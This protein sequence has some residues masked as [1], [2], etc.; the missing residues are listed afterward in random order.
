[1]RILYVAMKYDYG[2]LEQGYSFEHYNFYHS[3]LHMGHDIIYFDFMTLMQKYGRKRMNRLLLEAVRAKKPG[4]LF[5]V[6]F[7]NELDQNV[8]R[9][10]SESTDIVTLNWFCDDH[11]RFDSFSRYWAPCFDSVVT[12]AKSALPKYEKLGYRNVIKSQWACN[13]FLYRKLDLP[14]EY[15]VTF[16]GQPYGNRREILQALRDAGINVQMWGSG[17]ESGR[18]SQENMICI[19]NQSRI[20]LNLPKAST[21]ISTPEARARN[22]ARRLLSCSLNIVPFG[23]QLKTMGKRWLS[24][25]RHPTSAVKTADLSK[26]PDQIKARNFEI[27][28]C[29]GFLLTGLAEDLGNYYEVG[30]EIVCFEDVDSLIEKLHYYLRHG[31]ERAAIAQAGYQRTLSEHTYVH[32]FTQIFQ[33][34]G[35]PHRPLSAVLEGKVRPGR[36]EEVR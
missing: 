20:N 2:K 8:I 23:S 11:W 22:V 7:T 5:C 16:V 13:H 30:K 32:R 29:G 15:D 12:T 33:R 27:P 4:L 21:P 9:E 36:M 24:A 17:W 10:I 18:L 25:I 34:L 26:Y 3:L 28:G 1:M 31:D 6:L 14:L 19:F 35:L